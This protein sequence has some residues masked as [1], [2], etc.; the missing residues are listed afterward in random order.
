MAATVEHVSIFEPLRALLSNKTWGIS[1]Q[2]ASLMMQENLICFDEIRSLLR[3]THSEIALQAA[4][5]LAYY[6]Q[7]EEALKV[8]EEAFPAA[9]RQMKEYILHAISVIGSKSSL[10]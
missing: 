8:L 7:D 3:N 9:P 6:A 5:I 4:F 2:T 1:G 10:S